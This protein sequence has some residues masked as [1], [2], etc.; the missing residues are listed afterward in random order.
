VHS[1][2]GDWSDSL[3]H[4]V[5][6]LV[7]FLLALP[8]GW[9]RAREE[10]G[11]GMRTF[12]LVAMA[13]CGFVQTGISVIGPGATTQANIMQGVITG[14]GFIGAGAIMRQGEATT[15]NATAA[16]IWTV[17]IIGAAVGYGYFDIGLILAVANL[18]VL[19]FRV[20]LSAA[21]AR[22]SDDSRDLG[23]D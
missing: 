15:G 16:S 18:A 23:R 6:L 14:V 20:P 19:K 1:L 10:R 17:G 11:A 2:F 22:P 13:S 12:P 21:P 5:H 9:N 4:L 3:E 8:I 7:A